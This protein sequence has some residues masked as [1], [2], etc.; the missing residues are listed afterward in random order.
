MVDVRDRRIAPCGV[1]ARVPCARPAGMR[2]RGCHVR[3]D[4]A[5]RTACECKHIAPV[6]RKRD[7]G[8]SHCEPRRRHARALLECRWLLWKA[9]MT[10]RRRSRRDRRRV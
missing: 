6:R 5:A 7:R 3:G 1:T 4:A 10:R 8:G 2:R 9:A